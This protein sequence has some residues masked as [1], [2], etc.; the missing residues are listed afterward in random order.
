MG[1]T[2]RY[3]NAIHILVQWL[4]LNKNIYSIHPCSAKKFSNFRALG[5]ARS[6]VPDLQR[7]IRIKFSLVICNLMIY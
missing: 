1:V 6:A 7:G 2:L 4:E 5:I 3:V